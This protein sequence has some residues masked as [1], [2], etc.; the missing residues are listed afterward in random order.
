MA[1]RSEAIMIRVLLW[2]LGL[3]NDRFTET[4]ASPPPPKP[5][6]CHLHGCC[7]PACPGHVLCEPH[8]ISQALDSYDPQEGFGPHS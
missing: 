6:E 1:S 2:L 7:M 5:T 8:L 4:F 3:L